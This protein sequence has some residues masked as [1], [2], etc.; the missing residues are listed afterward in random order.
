MQLIL[1]GDTRPILF[2]MAQSADHVSGLAGASPA[3]TVSKNGGAFAAPAGA[4]AEV[5][6]GWYRL[7][8]TGGDVTTN[9]VFLLHA[10]AAGGDP[11]RQ[12]DV[13]GDAIAAEFAR[14]SLRPSHQRQT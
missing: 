13:G 1:N 5:G 8:P 4:V 2:F 10:T 7:T 14:Q 12:Y 3:V 6:N 11:A 9:G